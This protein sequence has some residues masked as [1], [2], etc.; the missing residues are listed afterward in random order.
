[1]AI[2]LNDQDTSAKL[3]P[4]R[5]LRLVHLLVSSFIILISLIVIY[6]WIYKQASIIQIIPNAPPM[7]FN[8]A[9]CFLIAGIAYLSIIK[10]R[11]FA[12]ILGICLATFSFI[13]F[14]QY[15]HS[16]NLYIDTLLIDPFYIDAPSHPGRMSPNTAIC[17]ILAGLNIFVFSYSNITKKHCSTACFVS[18]LLIGVVALTSLFG[19]ISNI[20]LTYSWGSNTGMA[21]HTAFCFI[22]I[23][24]I[25]LLLLW[26]DSNTIKKYFSAFLPTV[27][28]CSF[29]LFFTLFYF[30]FISFEYHRSLNNMKQNKLF[31]AEKV[32]GL[33][34]GDVNAIRRLYSRINSDTY[35]SRSNLNQDV[36][37]YIDDIKFIEIIEI[38]KSDY[39]LLPIAYKRSSISQNASNML[40]K[41]CRKNLNAK[42]NPPSD[43]I[44]LS[45]I[46]DH[47][48]ISDNALNLLSIINIDTILNSIWENNTTENLGLEI[49]QGNQSFYTKMPYKNVYVEQIDSFKLDLFGLKLV[50]NIFLVENKFLDAEYTRTTL[51]FIFLGI[52]FSILAGLCVS[53]WQ[54]LYRKNEDFKQ[55]FITLKQKESSLNTILEQYHLTLKSADM[56]TWNWNIDTGDSSCDSVMLY[57]FDIES[58]DEINE[59]EKALTL[60]HPDDQQK[61]ENAVIDALAEKVKYSCDYRIIRKDG[62]VRF[63]CARGKFFI[64]PKD[65]TNILSG[66]CWDATEEKIAKEKAFEFENQIIAMDEITD[67]W[68]DWNLATNEGYFSPGFKKMFGYADHEI[69]NTSTGWKKIVNA[70]DM[71]HFLDNMNAHIKTNAIYPLYQQMRY[72]H[73]NGHTVWVICRGRGLKNAQGVFVR[74][75][76]THTDITQAKLNEQ[77]LE[78]LASFD[79]LT[80]LPNRRSFIEQLN[81][82]VE[83]AKRNE[84][85]IAVFFIDID[86]FKS[87]NDNYGHAIG[88]KLLIQVSQKLKGTL[89]VVDYLAR[90]SGDEFAVILSD[91]VD[92]EGLAT[93]A[94]KCI[95]ALN[96]KVKIEEYNIMCTLSIG[97]AIYS[98][99]GEDAATLLQQADTAMYSAKEHGKNQFAFYS[100]NL[101]EKFYRKTSIE[102]ALRQAIQND[103][104]I[105]YYQPQIDIVKNKVVGVEALIRWKNAKLDNPTPDEFIP[106]AENSKSILAIGNWVAEKSFRDYVD[107]IST[108]NDPDFELA[109]NVS[110]QQIESRLFAELLEM[111]IKRHKLKANSIT[112]EIT[113]TTLMSHIVSCEKMLRHFSDLGIKIALDDF[114]TGYSSLTYLK[115]LPFNY[116]KV[117]KNFVDDITNNTGD[118][119]ILKAIINLADELNLSCI[120]EGVETQEQLDFLR[121][122]QCQ[123][124]QGYFFAKP[125]PLEELIQF[126]KEFNGQN[127]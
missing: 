91:I 15:I 52:I 59:L 50:F 75:V 26:E 88:D 72:R 96:G 32:Q 16:I 87:I 79:A 99:N 118:S 98:N 64:D 43:D 110:T 117:D 37:N 21:I 123:Y 22:A 84:K 44:S 40:I 6:G 122:S 9:F 82:S 112:I 25:S 93:A 49:T 71:G 27:V 57:L 109:I 8:T 14:I 3:T 11:I 89:R 29:L 73:K 127:N 85:L 106:I 36:Q 1:M 67:G 102:V 19:Y 68:W 120:A 62:T 34:T 17:F 107:I 7:Q 12:S 23:S 13:T 101:N 38:P 114:G 5:Y 56:G 111:L 48:C 92:T 45:L 42:N 63:I 24:I 55:T 124:V 97:I 60:I 4:S 105:L 83:R 65:N 116:I 81:Q 95:G 10:Y 41:Q 35:Q 125:M 100:T 30:A 90:L 104:F 47:I 18:C 61:V 78:K 70:E 121:A 86:N 2:K 76:G 33:L 39:N 80:N 20:I 119:I 94:S 66:V 108:I 113:E 103:E 69:E 54:K 46:P 51:L 74:V 58:S 115:A 126:V 53:L 31:I 28:S 77:K